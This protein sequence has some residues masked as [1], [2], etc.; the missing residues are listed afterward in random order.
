MRDGKCPKCGSRQIMTD[1][2]V[3]DDGRNSSHPLYVVVDEP[4][5]ANHGAVWVQAQSIGEIHAWICAECGYTEL[6]TGNLNELYE[7]YRKNH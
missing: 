2:E 3:R 4:E 7:S 5:P 1:V 6:Y